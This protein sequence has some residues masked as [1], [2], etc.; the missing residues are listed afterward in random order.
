MD[1]VY[2]TWIRS[3]VFKIKEW[4]V[5]GESIWTNNDVEGWHN[6]LNSRCSNRGPVPFY[7]LIQE[8]FKEATAIPLQVRMISEGN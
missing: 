5:Y 1:Y 3:R 4:S 7:P 6:R 8:L 2:N